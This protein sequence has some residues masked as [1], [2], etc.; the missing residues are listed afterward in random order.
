MN[1][2]KQR[3]LHNGNKASIEGKIPKWQMRIEHL[4]NNIRQD[5]ELLTYYKLGHLTR[6]ITKYAKCF[7]NNNVHS[8]EYTLYIF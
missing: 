1:K 6:K 4:S 2:A 3:L 5:P 8:L 7:A